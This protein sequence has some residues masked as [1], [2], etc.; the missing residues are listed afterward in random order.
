MASPRVFLFLRRTGTA[1][2]VTTLRSQTVQTLARLLV[3]L[4]LFLI[5]PMSAQ[6]KPINMKESVVSP[7]KAKQ[8][9]RGD[10]ETRSCITYD[11]EQKFVIV[12]QTLFNQ[13]VHDIPI[14][15]LMHIV[16]PLAITGAFNERP[17]DMVV[18]G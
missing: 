9:C 13:G 17:F 12:H 2:S 6:L 11:F 14:R 16:D 4:Y 7:T 5:S 3:L 1:T 8:A 10:A 18:A 15:V